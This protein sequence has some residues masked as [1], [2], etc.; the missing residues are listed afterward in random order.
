MKAKVLANPLVQLQQ[1]DQKANACTKKKI[2]EQ[3]EELQADVEC[4]IS[5]RMNF[6]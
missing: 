6:T 4:T 5:I 1:N 3:W 2:I